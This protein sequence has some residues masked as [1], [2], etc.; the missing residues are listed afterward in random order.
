M[1][2]RIL[3]I[4]I[5]IIGT[6]IFVL[7]TWWYFTN[8]EKPKYSSWADY[9]SNNIISPSNVPILVIIF[10]WTIFFWTVYYYASFTKEYYA[11]ESYQ[12]VY[13]AL[14]MRV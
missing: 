3:A 6:V 2:K 13:K 11:R 1:D 8:V 7:G 9:T 5:L 4:I 12:T 10:S 14:R